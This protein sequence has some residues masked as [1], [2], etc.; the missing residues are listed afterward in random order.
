MHYGMLPKKCP[1][2]HG[3]LP[4]NNSQASWLLSSLHERKGVSEDKGHT[5]LTSRVG[6]PLGCCVTSGLELNFSMS[7]SYLQ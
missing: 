5:S 3:G 4:L 6:L 2:R 7:F 1:S